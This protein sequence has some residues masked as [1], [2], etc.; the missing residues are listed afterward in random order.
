M[1][2]KKLG[3]DFF[4]GKAENVYLVYG[5]ATR[6][7]TDK[8]VNKPHYSSA[9]ALGQDADGIAHYLDLDAWRDRA[10]DLKGI[11]KGDHVLALGK[12][13]T[14]EYNDK[15]FTSLNVMWVSASGAPLPVPSTARHVIEPVFVPIDDDEE[16][17]DD[18][19]LPF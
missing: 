7:A 15:T 18:G 11:R 8:T 13:E 14:R 2:M 9:L 3:E 6:D 17:S 1:I 4:N 10:T 12:L 16:E 5:V 19:E